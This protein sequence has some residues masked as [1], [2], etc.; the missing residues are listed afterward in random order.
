MATAWPSRSARR[1]RI[2]GGSLIVLAGV[3]IHRTTVP[4]PRPGQP[5]NR[6]GGQLDERATRS[7]IEEDAL[8]GVL[9][10]E[11]EAGDRDPGRDGQDHCPSR[12]KAP[13]LTWPPPF[14][15]EGNES[16]HCEDASDDERCPKVMGAGRTAKKRDLAAGIGMEH[17]AAPKGT[18][19][20]CDVRRDHRR[21]DHHCDRCHEQPRQG[22]PSARSHESM[23]ALDRRQRE[24]SSQGG[25]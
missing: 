24:A 12:P 3:L 25:H 8:R 18:G 5:K 14:D 6:H 11:P 21:A 16:D 2:R 1:G 4:H 23:L 17:R 10:E 9:D 7:E 22:Q 15:D 13:V 19:A 20:E